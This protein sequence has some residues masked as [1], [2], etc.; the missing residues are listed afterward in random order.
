MAGLAKLN[1]PTDVALLSYEYLFGNFSATNAFTTSN[2]FTTN[3]Y[4]IGNLIDTGNVTPGYTTL[5]ITGNV[6]AS[7]ALTTNSIYANTLSLS[8]IGSSIILTG[9]ITAANA[10]TTGN[11]FAGGI[12]IVGNGAP[13]LTTVSVANNLLVSN[14]I[15]TTN[16]FTGNLLMSGNFT[17][18]GLTDKTSLNVLGNTAVSNAL[19][20]TNVFTGNVLSSG[21]VTIGGLLGKT[22]LDVTTGNAYF[23]NALTSSNV[24]AIGSIIT[25][26]LSA[27]NVTVSNAVSTNNVWA[28]NVYATG[29]MSFAGLPGLTT[30]TLAGNVLIS[31]TLTTTNVWTNNVYATGN[32]SLTGLPGLTTMNITGNAVFANTLSTT[33]VWTKTVVSSGLMS[34]SGLPGLTTVNVTGNVLIANA[35][36]TNNVYTGNLFGTGDFIITG[37]V[38]SGILTA[39]I[40]GNAYVSN[41]ISTTN[42]FASTLTS[43]TVYITGNIYAS[44]AIQTQNIWAMNVYASNL[45][46]GTSTL[47]A[48]PLTKSIGANVWTSTQAS[49]LTRGTHVPLY[50]ESAGVAP[51]VGTVWTGDTYSDASYM[52]K[53]INTASPAW[54][55]IS[56][57][58]PTN[59]AVN[60]VGTQAFTTSATSLI[61]VTQTVDP[62]I[63]GTVTWRLT[64]HPSNVYVSNTSSRGC[65]IVV[66][67]T[68]QATSSSTVTVTA[69][70]SIG[71]SSVQAFLLNLTAPTILLGTTRDYPVSNASILRQFTSTN[72][73][74]WYQPPNT[75][76]Q[77]VQLY[78]NFTNATAG[79]GLVLVARGRE[80]TDWWNSGGQ[81]FS[82]TSTTLTSAG[83]NI[84][85]PIAVL[86][87][88][89]VNSL[90]GNW[91]NM[92]MVVNRTTS[93]LNDS[94]YYVGTSDGPF[95]WNYFRAGSGNNGVN[96]FNPSTRVRINVSRYTGTFRTGT[97]TA[98]TGD[99]QNWLDWYPTGINDCTRIFTTTWSGHSA[100]STQ[101]QGWSAGASCTSGYQT[102]NNEGHTLQ[103]VHCYMEC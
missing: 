15:A 54:R 6:S 52:Y 22:T 19:I 76:T 81:N 94:L 8:N 69:V 23:S 87:D 93:G 57:L 39:N 11:V 64:N 1:I 49:T 97:L 66:P 18:G 10:F 44:N 9:N 62:A 91:R 98:Q 42:V 82:S 70:N 79:M 63:T 59:P 99:T 61:H 46:V 84:N 78:T 30:A 80:S 74:Y 67:T 83:L 5:T 21:N 40:V 37:G 50:V 86:P 58:N 17:V 36:T 89:F 75:S 12:M 35:L 95:S 34:V 2:I 68:S 53:Y 29:N 13:T 43:N 88:R 73:D 4:L 96:E 26:T 25:P 55:T 71:L 41:A 65:T 45:F 85:T 51:S 16:V 90:I 24:Y 32:M 60:A 56:L 7:N 48:D 102:I 100:S 33:N 20:T 27:S 14:A 38:T 47:Y 3:V 28:T 101:W 77:P 103:L 72:G 92:R 31:N